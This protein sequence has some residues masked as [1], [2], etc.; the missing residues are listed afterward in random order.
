MFNKI[1]FATDLSDR[2]L[3]ALRYA[4]DL[5]KSYDAEITM[6]HVVSE[7][8]NKDE[9]VMLRVSPQHFREA[10]KQIAVSAKEIMEEELK[11]IGA[12]KVK[13]KLILREGKPSREIINT[14]NELEMDLLVITTLGRTGIDEKLVGSTAE[15]IVRYCKIPVL[16]VPC[17]E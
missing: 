9:M 13:H 14:A 11:R 16:T 4:V 5:A 7:F 2:S 3:K 6:L 8:M 17:K 10:Q 12:T 1:M 15:H